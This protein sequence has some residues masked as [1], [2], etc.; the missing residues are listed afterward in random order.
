MKQEVGA[1]KQGV[2]AIIAA[3][4]T[5]TEQVKG[6]VGRAPGGTVVGEPHP[7]LHLYLVVL[8]PTFAGKA[9]ES[10]RSS[11]KTSA[12][13]GVGKYPERMGLDF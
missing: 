5:G 2:R 10:L 11:T 9:N 1:T 4:C 8:L 6:A 7:P 3:A 12:S 13:D